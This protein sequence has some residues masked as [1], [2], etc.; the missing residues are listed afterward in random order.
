M[1]TSAAQPS[2]GRLLPKPRPC[3]DGSVGFDARDMASY[4]GFPAGFDGAGTT[5]AFVSLSGILRRQDVDIYFSAMPTPAPAIEVLSLPGSASTPA[6][7]AGLAVSLELLGSVAPGARLAVY[8]AGPTE[9]GVVDGLRAAIH[10]RV[11]PADVVCLTW[12]LDEAS[13][14]PA[15]AGA[16]HQAMEEATAFGLPVCAP[17]GVWADGSLHPVFPGTHPSVLACGRTRAVR[18]GAGLVEQP[19][20][21]TAGPPAASILFRMEPWRAQAIG[22]AG[23]DMSH[24]PVPD[25]SALADQEI[26]YR[27]H[28]NGVW[29][30]MP[31][32]GAAACLWA[33]LLARLRQA[34]GRPWDVTGSLYRTLGPAGSLSPVAASRPGKAPG[35]DSRVGWG[36]PDGQRMLAKLSRG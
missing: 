13:L 12:T 1:S 30:S 31:G 8:L 18:Q 35:W 28:I 22:W 24:R 34:L 19:M 14:S 2:A 15:L 10:G 33:G 32:A 23:A 25:V 9:Q 36:S 4:Y 7:D 16:I 17:A 20:A 6:A 21:S 3:A 5:I 11:R 26:G 29:A 27:V